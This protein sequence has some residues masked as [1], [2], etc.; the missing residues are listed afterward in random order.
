MRTREGDEEEGG[1]PEE[2]SGCKRRVMWRID[3]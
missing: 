3:E 2:G 1:K